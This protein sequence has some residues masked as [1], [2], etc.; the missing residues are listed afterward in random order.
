M[1]N[2]I[3]IQPDSDSQAETTLNDIGLDA[4]MGKAFEEKH[5][6][7]GLYENLHDLFLPPQHPP[8][9]LTS[10]P[11]PVPDRMKV[12]A[13][14]WAIGIATGV[15]VIILLVVLFYAGKKIINTADKPKENVAQID[16]GV[17]KGPKAPK[18]A[19]GGGGGGEHNKIEP[20][21]GHLPKIE[22][23]PVVK[24]Q[25]QTVLKPKLAV[26]P[27]IDVQK[28]IILPDNPA[29]PTIGVKNSA[30][31]ALAS[32]GQG[33]NGGMGTGSHGGL[34]SGNGN[35]YG[36]G[37]GGNT[38]GGVYSIGG[39]VSRPVLLRS[40]DAEF[41]EEARRNKY[42][43]V[44]V[45]SII[46]DAQGNPQNPRI[47]RALGMGLD[48]EAIKAVLQY[49]FRPAFKDGKMPVPVHMNVE[50]DFHLY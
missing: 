27:A 42:Q 44:V 2:N 24:P 49:K 12:K 14:P 25:V 15:N 29:L 3:P 5:I 36:A 21:K 43:G 4:L 7:A 48:Q 45:V 1:A 41:S 9:E 37:N 19:G 11:I 34:G 46:V 10:A 8:L 47:V 31:V 28:K 13:N 20:T 40:V 35:G 23:V 18:T 17:F 33:S 39:G 6:W 32:N 50:I 26:T 38:G 16:V 30:N 22:K